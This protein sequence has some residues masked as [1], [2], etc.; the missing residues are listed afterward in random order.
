[1]APKACLAGL[2]KGQAEPKYKTSKCL[3]RYK[4]EAL[5]VPL[6]I[7]LDCSMDF[8]YGLAFRRKN[9]QTL[10]CDRRREQKSHWHGG[11]L[12]IDSSAGGLR[13]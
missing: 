5:T 13:A 9:F 8:M 10:Q 6:G 12:H 11:G 3:I 1:M 4:L 2:Q 7:N